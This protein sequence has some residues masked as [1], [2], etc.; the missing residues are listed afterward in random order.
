MKRRIIM[1]APIV[2]LALVIGSGGLSANAAVNLKSWIGS[3]YSEDATKA[4]VVK[5]CD[6]ESDGRAVHADYKRSGSGTMQIIKDG[7]GSGNGCEQTGAG[8][9]VTQHRIVEEVPVTG[10]L[11]GAW[12]YPS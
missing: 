5:A 6:G 3:N 8:V 10:D 11:L 2:A 1:S 4:T 7:N 12:K 9:K